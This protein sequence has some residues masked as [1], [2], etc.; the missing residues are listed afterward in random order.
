MIEFLSNNWATI[1]S[2][3]AAV[4]AVAVI[5]VQFTPTQIDDSVLRRV[6]SVIEVLA[7]LVTPAAKQ[8]TPLKPD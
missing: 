7:G 1:L 3:L 5:I 2:L 4:H 8:N 6:W